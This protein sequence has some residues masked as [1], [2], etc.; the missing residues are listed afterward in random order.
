MDCIC[1]NL[2]TVILFLTS[3]KISSGTSPRYHVCLYKKARR[4]SKAE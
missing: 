1:G 2:D 4:D 3:D